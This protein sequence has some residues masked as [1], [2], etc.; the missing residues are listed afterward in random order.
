[1]YL[2]IVLELKQAVNYLLTYTTS[3]ERLN[4]LRSA[5]HSR[6]PLGEGHDNRINNI[7]II[8]KA[9]SRIATHSPN[10]KAL[11]LANKYFLFVNSMNSPFTGLYS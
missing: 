2:H 4:H 8:I 6:R 11:S 3:E 10:P 9:V 1:M 7:N 5:H